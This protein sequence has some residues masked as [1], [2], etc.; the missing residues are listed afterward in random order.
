MH[1]EPADSF[2]QPHVYAAPLDVVLTSMLHDLAR[3]PAPP[4]GPG[5]CK[6]VDMNFAEFHFHAVR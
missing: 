4:I 5:L 2:T 1:N 3:G 6:I